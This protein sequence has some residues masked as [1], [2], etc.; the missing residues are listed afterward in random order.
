MLSIVFIIKVRIQHSEDEIVELGVYKT[1]FEEIHSGK[2]ENLRYFLT[3]KKIVQKSKNS[4]KIEKG[5][6]T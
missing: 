3:S 2:L 4:T 5:N 1:A 6:I